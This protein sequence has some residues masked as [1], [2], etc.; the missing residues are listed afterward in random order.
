[1]EEEKYSIIFGDNFE[2]RKP[3]ID[4]ITC[5]FEPV[6]R[7]L[8]VNDTKATSMIQKDENGRPIKDEEGNML[9]VV[10]EAGDPVY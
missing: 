2:S 10:K 7:K 4:Q 1:M 6:F 8:S 9:R 3:T 5:L